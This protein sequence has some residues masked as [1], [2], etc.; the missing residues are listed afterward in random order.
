MLVCEHHGLYSPATQS[1]HQVKVDDTI[2]ESLFVSQ[3][4]DVHLDQREGKMSLN[5]DTGASPLGTYV[6]HEV[7]SFTLLIFINKNGGSVE[8]PREHFS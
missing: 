3:V 4:D 2:V 5:N 6:V 1:Q 7:V 8:L